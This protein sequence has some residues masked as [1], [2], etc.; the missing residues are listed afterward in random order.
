MGKGHAARKEKPQGRPQGK[1]NI[2]RLEATGVVSRCPK[3]SSTDREAYSRN[4]TIVQAV[5]GAVE[6]GTDKPVTHMIFRT[7][8]CL[9]CG[10]HRRDITYLYSPERTSGE[11]QSDLEKSTA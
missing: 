8:R 10:Q 5:A 4:R 9:T 2:E 11:I 3:C 7:T 6:P 1:A